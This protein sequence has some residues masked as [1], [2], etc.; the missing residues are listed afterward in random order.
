MLLRTSAKY[1]N[2]DQPLER[3]MK[4]LGWDF[5]QTGPDEGEWLL[6]AGYIVARQGD[7][8]W[9]EDLVK[10]DQIASGAFM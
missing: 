7:A 4:M 10:A 2:M 5:Y 6:I 1:V 8:K 9:K 3:A